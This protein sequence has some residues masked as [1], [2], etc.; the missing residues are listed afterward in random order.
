LSQVVMKNSMYYDILKT[1]VG[2]NVDKYLGWFYDFW[3]I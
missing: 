1:L 3:K 2:E